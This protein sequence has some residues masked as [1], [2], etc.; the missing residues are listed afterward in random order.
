MNSISI[1]TKGI[2]TPVFQGG[3]NGSGGAGIVHKVE[4]LLKP[5]ILVT[6]V[7][8]EKGSIKTP[9]TEET[10]KVKSLKIIVDQ[11]D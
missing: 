1:A 6:D 11:K 7:S 2:I 5:N 10:F 4:E 8:M 9:I 3:G